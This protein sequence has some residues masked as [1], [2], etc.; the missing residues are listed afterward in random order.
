MNTG[1]KDP[2]L[3]KGA[4]GSHRAE[5]KKT[6]TVL[7]D[8]YPNYYEK[9]KVSGGET[10][11]GQ[12]WADKTHKNGSQHENYNLKNFDKSQYEH[13]KKKKETTKTIS[14]KVSKKT[15]NMEKSMEKEW[16]IK[17]GPLH[18]PRDGKQPV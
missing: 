18:W 6:I 13:R 8:S 15:S 1:Q 14:K 7:G 3:S 11:G 17:D 12:E 9:R 16:P 10:G 5:K 2:D 4:G